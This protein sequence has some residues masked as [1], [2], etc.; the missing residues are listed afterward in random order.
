MEEGGG[1]ERVV[2]P[3]PAQEPVG[4]AAQLGVGPGDDLVARVGIA[5]LPGV[6]QIRDISRHI[7]RARRSRV[8][9]LSGDAG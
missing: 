9:V 1:L 6:Q 2:A 5:S 3:L 8:P 7:R 4:D